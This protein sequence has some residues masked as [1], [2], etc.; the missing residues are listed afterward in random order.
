MRTIETKV[1]K[2]DELSTEAQKKAVENLFDINVDH[3]W[4]EFTYDDAE[5]IG[6]RITSFDLDRNKNA[7]GEFMTIGGAEITASLLIKEHGKGCET[8]KLA[9]RF[10]SDLQAIEDKFT[11]PEDDEERDEEIGLLSD[12]FLSDLLELYADILQ[13]ECDYLQSEES[14]IETIKANDYEFTEEGKLI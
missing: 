14:I 11:G 1:Y 5:N 12:T 7:K 10:I 3:N 13:E 9:I 8:N 6:L 4:W 2:F